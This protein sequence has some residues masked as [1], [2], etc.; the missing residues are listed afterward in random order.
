MPVISADASL[1]RNTIAPVEVL[2][3]AEAAELDL[4]QHLVTER[5]VLEERLASSASR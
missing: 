3:L 1:A 5:L 2:E 4:A